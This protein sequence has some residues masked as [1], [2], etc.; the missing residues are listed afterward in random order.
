MSKRQ[1]RDSQVASAGDGLS[2]FQRKCEDMIK[3]GRFTREHRY[4]CPKCQDLT[5]C[6]QVVSGKG[7]FKNELYSAVARCDCVPPIEGSS[8]P[9]VNEVNDARIKRGLGRAVW[10]HKGEITEVLTEERED[11]RRK[12]EAAVVEEGD[13]G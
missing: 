5:L 2:A 4:K 7:P 9:T 3:R 12:F 1:S 10:L 13:F 6:Y 8:I 11:L